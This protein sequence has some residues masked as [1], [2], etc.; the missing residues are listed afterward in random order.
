MQSGLSYTEE[1]FK[2]MAKVLRQNGWIYMLHLGWCG[3]RYG[4]TGMYINQAFD[5]L[6][7]EFYEDLL[8][9]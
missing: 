2:A 3:P 1:E 8:N 6:K 5:S 4:Q 7:Q 9:D